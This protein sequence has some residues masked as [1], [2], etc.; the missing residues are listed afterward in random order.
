MDDNIYKFLW[1]DK[2]VQKYLE[3]LRKRRRWSFILAVF[4]LA[5]FI[6]GYFAEMSMLMGPLFSVF[7]ALFYAFIITREINDITEARKGKNKHL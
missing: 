1:D 4:F 6:F 5:F 3:S 2:K 7:L